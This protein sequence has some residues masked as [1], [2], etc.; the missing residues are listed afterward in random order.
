MGKLARA[1]L[2]GRRRGLH[3]LRSTRRGAAAA[4]RGVPKLGVPDLDRAAF[5]VYEA[6]GFAVRS[7]DVRKVYPHHGTLGCLVNVLARR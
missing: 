7:L 6:E 5:A 4:S 2:R 3:P 1:D